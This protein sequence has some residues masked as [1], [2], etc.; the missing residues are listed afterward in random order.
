MEGE[1]VLYMAV[2]VGQLRGVKGVLNAYSKTF[3]KARKKKQMHAFLK[4]KK[5]HNRTYGNGFH[6]CRFGPS[7]WRIL[8]LLLTK[9]LDCPAFSTSFMG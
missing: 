9:T 6:A 1:V 3:A 2:G 8:L 4:K 5:I 7:I